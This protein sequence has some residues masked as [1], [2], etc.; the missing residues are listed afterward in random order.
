MMAWENT[1]YFSK[2]APVRKNNKDDLITCCM[3][4]LWQIIYVCAKWLYLSVTRPWMYPGNYGVTSISCL[5][6]KP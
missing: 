2:T 3:N 4:S 1:S 6:E 5:F